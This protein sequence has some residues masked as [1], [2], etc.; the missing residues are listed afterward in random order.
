MSK[1][2]KDSIEYIL[3]IGLLAVA[4]G[5]LLYRNL[6]PSDQTLPLLTRLLI[7]ASQFLQNWWFAII[8]LIVTVA[9][10]I[11]RGKRGRLR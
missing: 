4:I 8:A 9:F 2:R 6:G 11:E 3:L 1:R 10:A 5:T 7:T